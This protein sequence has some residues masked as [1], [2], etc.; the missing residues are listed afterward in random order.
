MK[1]LVVVLAVLCYSV[2]T[3]SIT[4]QNHPVNKFDFIAY[5]Q[6]GAS[7]VCENPNTLRAAKCVCYLIFKKRLCPGNLQRSRRLC[8][9]T[10]KSAKKVLSFKST[11]K[12]FM[13]NKK[14]SVKKLEKI[15]NIIL[16]KCIPGSFP[17][18]RLKLC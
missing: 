11:C 13:K 16:K 7:P 10:F 3:F 5:R 8:V 18:A 9:S 2:P 4:V 17:T 14:I 1:L 6:S 12:N 15:I